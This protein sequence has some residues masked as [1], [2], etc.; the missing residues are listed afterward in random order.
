MKCLQLST[1][2]LSECKPETFIGNES[3]FIMTSL[4]SS[5]ADFESSCF[6]SQILLR[7]ILIHDIVVCVCNM[8]EHQLLNN[9]L[10]III[11]PTHTHQ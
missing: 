10:I 2:Y 7:F 8:S 4:E 5:A 1:S 6:A 3:C 9:L 11:I